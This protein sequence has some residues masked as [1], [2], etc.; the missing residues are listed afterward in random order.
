MSSGQLDKAEGMTYVNQIPAIARAADPTKR[1]TLIRCTEKI[2]DCEENHSKVFLLTIDGTDMRDIIEGLKELHDKITETK[3]DIIIATI[4]D[5][6]VL[7]RKAIEIVFGNSKI[8][9]SLIAERRL[10]NKERKPLDS[11]IINPGALT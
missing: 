4:I 7:A 11:I 3:A 5:L 2:G 6:K 10:E 9:F 1:R 8:N